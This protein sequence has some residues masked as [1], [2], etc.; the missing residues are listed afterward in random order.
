MFPVSDKEFDFDVFVG[1]V[2]DQFAF[3]AFYFLCL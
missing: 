3:T 1:T 2:S